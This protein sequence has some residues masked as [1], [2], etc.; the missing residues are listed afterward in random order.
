MPCIQATLA[1]LL[2]S[3]NFSD[4]DVTYEVVSNFPYTK[5]HSLIGGVTEAVRDAKPDWVYSDDNAADISI[6]V[7]AV[8]EMCCL[9]VV[10]GSR[11]YQGFYLRHAAPVQLRN[12]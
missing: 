11:E 8:R 12:D 1:E 5:Q 10:K 2:K 3:A 7:Y 4:V 6:I 9:S